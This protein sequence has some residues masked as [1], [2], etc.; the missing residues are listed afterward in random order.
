M[1]IQNNVENVTHMNKPGSTFNG[2]IETIIHVW[3]GR[4]IKL[5]LNNIRN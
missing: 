3:H 1:I 2:N 5:A 4:E